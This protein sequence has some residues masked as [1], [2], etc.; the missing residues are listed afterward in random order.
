MHGLIVNREYLPLTLSDSRLKA[1]SL[2][3]IMV[4]VKGENM[5]VDTVQVDEKAVLDI[6]QSK[7]INTFFQPVISISTKS[8]IGFEA[9]SRGGGDGICVIDPTLLFHD[10]LQPTM[11]IDVDRLCREKALTYFKPIHGGHKDMCLFLNI[12]PEILP[13]VE[14]GSEVLKHQVASM[15]IDFGSV[16]IECTLKQAVG[17]SVETFAALYRDFGFKISLDG[18][19]VDD[20]FSPIIS[21]IKPDFVKITPTFFADGKRKDYSPKVLEALMD[22]ANRCGAVV[23]AQGVETEEESIR[24]LSAGVQ[25]QQGYYYTKDDGAKTND[26]AKMF[27]DKIIATYDKFKRVKQELVR[28]KKNR[29]NSTFQTVTSVSSKF[30]NLPENRFDDACKTLVH[31]VDE[32]IS[33]FVLTDTGVQLTSRHHVRTTV[34]KASSAKIIGSSKGV[35]HSVNDYVMYLDMGYEKFV[36][37][38]FVSHYT[39]DEACIISRPFYNSEGQRF[40]LCVELPYPG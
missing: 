24:L 5:S 33:M 14:I 40:I 17:E 4:R 31:N 1:L 39:G 6:L 27:F 10:D 8:I 15:D 22:V 2:C 9:F 23:V 29:F 12:N 16:A 36:T 19:T 20:P 32:L 26:P 18:C 25:L 34:R 37:R 11:K 35:D 7:N 3:D 21:R 28:R 38:P 30:A 13:H